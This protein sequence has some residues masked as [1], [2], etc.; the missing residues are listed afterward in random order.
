MIERIKLHN[1]ASYKEEVEMSPTQINYLY[2]SNGT[3][4]STLGKVIHKI[5]DYADCELNWKSSAVNCEVYNKEYV[6]INFRKSQT[7]KGI[8][9]LGKDSTEAQEFIEKAKAEIEN[10]ITQIEGLETSLS[11]KKTELEEAKEE[12]KKKCWSY[13]K[14]Y[15]DEFRTA[16]TSFMGSEESFFAKC[17]SEVDNDSD[18]LSESELKDKAEKIFSSDAKLY[19]EAIEIDFSNIAENENN[20]LL[21]QKIVGK[22]DLEIGK[23]IQRLNNSDWVNTGRS[24]LEKS[25]NQC[26]FCQQEIADS[27]KDEI[28]SFFDETYQEKIDQLNQFKTNYETF[29]GSFIQKLKAALNR[30][31]PHFDF[32]TLDQRIEV[33]EERIK[34]NLQKLSDKIEAPSTSVSL[35]SLQQD[36][37]QTKQL[38]EDYKKA[39]SDNNTTFENLKE[40]QTQLTSEIWR[41]IT[42][43][44]QIDLES[45]TKRKT[46][47]EKAKESIGK[48]IK[49]QKERTRSLE[50]DIKTKEFEIT[51]VEHT[52]NEINKILSSF[53]FTDF[54]LAEAEQKSYKLVRPDG[55]DAKESLSEG[56]YTFITFLYFYHSLKGS[57]ESTG[58][59]RDKTVI[60]DDPISSLDSNVLFIISHLVKSLVRDTKEGKN[61]MKQIFI[62]THNVYFYK[63]VTFKGSG[64]HDSSEESFW[65][66]R[67]PSGA[68]KIIQ[69]VKNP[70]KTTYEL[71]W[72]ELDD[73]ESVNVATAFNT[74]RRILEYYFN[75]LGG[76]DYEKAINEFEGEE[77]LICKSLVSWI[78]DGSHFINDDLVVDAEPEVIEKYLKVFQD[79]FIKMGH[80]SHYDMMMKGKLVKEEVEE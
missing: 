47:S 68:S 11:N 73:I 72:R 69:K 13:K 5:S 62:L 48:T 7:I 57:Q 3:G 31:F 41:F 8:F 71:L 23:L 58:T 9:T 24:H 53:G 38:Y 6:E 79:I 77:L 80:K 70:I 14:K 59:T 34:L 75:I 54:H 27:L 22:E 36:F 4:K 33:I 63:E 65:L 2:G 37:E 60:I 67:K 55:T 56:E 15:S 28:N 43:E 19:E 61:G 30:D 50:K 21:E 12:A 26:P 39:I 49:Q 78:N 18:L 74:M 1:V 51:G 16:F 52:V 35:E 64:K 17:L 25:E 42:N 32:N 10:I 44:L 76:L 40:N 29:F 66:V 45:F 20:A 46:G